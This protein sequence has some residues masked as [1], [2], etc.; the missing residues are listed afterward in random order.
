MKARICPIV[1]QIWL[2]SFMVIVFIVWA[3]HKHISLPLG[4]CKPSFNINCCATQPSGLSNCG[5]KHFCCCC[6]YPVFDPQSKRSKP[7]KE[8][9]KRPKSVSYHS[10]V[11]YFCLPLFLKSPIITKACGPSPQPTV[12][13]LSANQQVTSPKAGFTQ[14]VWGGC[15]NNQVPTYLGS[16]LIIGLKWSS[17][18]M[19][20]YGDSSLNITSLIVVVLL[21]SRSK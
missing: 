1:Q 18:I 13:S 21:E 14:E 9:M 16:P 17:L 2:L 11:D 5:K 4:R 8:K 12:Y 7:H 10:T 20:T 19:C 15:G 6:C 3:F